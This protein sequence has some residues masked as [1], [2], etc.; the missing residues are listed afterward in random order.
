MEDLEPVHGPDSYST[1]T[2]EWGP[3]ETRIPVCRLLR[4]ECSAGRP[5]QISAALPK[6]L[7]E[8]CLPAGPRGRG[9]AHDAAQPAQTGEAP[10]L[11]GPPRAQP[12]G[13]RRAGMG[14]LCR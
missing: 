6:A 9:E 11:H 4:G 3:Q 5:C 13:G 1:E 12:G 7:V 8:V 10:G 14:P 2:A